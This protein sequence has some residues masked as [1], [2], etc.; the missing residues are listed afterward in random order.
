MPSAFTIPGPPLSNYV[1]LLWMYEGYATPHAQERILPT[2]V[3]ELV[4]SLDEDNRSGSGVAGARCEYTVLDTSRP[5]SIIGVHFKPGGGFPFFSP[6]AGEFHNVDVTLQDVWGRY[7][8]LVREQLLEATSAAARFRILTDALL[9]RSRDRL[10][11]HPAVRFALDAFGASPFSSVADVTG[12]IGLSAR[13]FADVFRNEVGLT[14]KLYCRVRRF[15]RVLGILER[16]AEVDW[17]DVALSCGYFDQAH[18]IHDFRAF[19]GVTPSQ[20]L[21]YRTSRNHV[22]VHD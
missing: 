12:Q 22:A 18:F 10:Q 20:Y 8:D 5:F 4:I 2:G 13:R 17:T 21:R 9:D 6:P 7:A 3:M 14:P 11:R 16:A 15:Q 19:S 1:D